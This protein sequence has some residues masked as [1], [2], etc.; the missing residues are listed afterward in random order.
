[1]SGEDDDDYYEGMLAPRLPPEVYQS[2]VEVPE[3][4]YCAHHHVASVERA[5]RQFRLQPAGVKLPEAGA[6]SDSAMWKAEVSCCSSCYI[7]LQNIRK[8]KDPTRRFPRP[9]FVAWL[10]FGLFPE[11]E[12]GP[13]PPL[14][15]LEWQCVSPGSCRRQMLLLVPGG[16][17]H[18]WRAGTDNQPGVQRGLRGHVIATHNVESEALAWLS[19]PVQLS[20]LAERLTVRASALPIL[21]LPFCLPPAGPPHGACGVVASPARTAHRGSVLRL[22]AT[23]AS[24]MC[25]IATGALPRWTFCYNSQRPHRTRPCRSSSPAGCPCQADHV[26]RSASRGGVKGEGH[27]RER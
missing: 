5:D 15:Y 9:D 11:D 23:L 13:L 17:A 21:R 4:V 7:G 8:V 20:R 18:A 24:L 14:T 6:H 10:D 3:D 2:L 22:R 1:M 12:K 16:E 26:T 27:H 19:V 25:A